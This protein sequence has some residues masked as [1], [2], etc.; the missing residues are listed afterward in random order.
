MKGIF[1]AIYSFWG[2]LVFAIA[3]LIVFPFVI[4][5]SFFPP[6]GT[7]ISYWFIRGWSKAFSILAFIPI[8]IINRPSREE[9]LG[10]IYISN[11]TSFLDAIAIVQG[12]P[13]AIKPLGKIEIL[14]IP[15]VGTIIGRFSVMVNRKDKESR[16]ESV[17]ALKSAADSNNAIMIFPEGTM[18]RTDQLL[19]KFYE[20][21]FRISDETG[22]PIR[23]IVLKNGGRLLPPGKLRLI[24][25][26]ITL[27][28]GPAI[29]PKI[30]I[31][32]MIETARN[33]MISKLQ[34]DN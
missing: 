18:N 15:I 17:E 5:F 1:I 27:E 9:A 3:M 24:P 26:Q 16:H 6:K 12:I 31:D 21:A 13:G 4:I 19:Q 10:H 34:D 28:F 7:I 8:K 23:P 30:G 2:M 33:W 29:D 25:G 32:A 14:K 22:L 20:G 11:H